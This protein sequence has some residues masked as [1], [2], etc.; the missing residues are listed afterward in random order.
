MADI[1]ASGAA[2]LADQLAASAA[3][4][5]VYY[6]GNSG[7][8]VYATVGVSR[9]EAQNSSGITETWESRDYIVKADALP[10]GEP[11]RHDLIVETL[12]GSDIRY[13]VSSPR[14]VAVFH[15]GDAYRKTIRIHTI[16]TT[17]SSYLQPTLLLRCWGASASTAIT[18]EQIAVLSNDMGAARGQIR[19]ITASGQYLYFVLPSSFGVPSFT[20]NG[21]TS[22]AW[23][24]TGRSIAFAGQASRAYTIYRSTYA[25]TG[26]ATVAVN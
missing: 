9:F 18:D 20:I 16:A 25:I 7:A 5:V 15:Y 19:Q 12:N 17:E 8:A 24:T 14:G 23:E 11:Q 26:A 22:T 4:S 6:R 3:R 2:W 13:E 21:L 1:L 10:F